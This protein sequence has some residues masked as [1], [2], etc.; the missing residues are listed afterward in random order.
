MQTYET[1]FIIRPNL[2]DEEVTKVVEKMKAVVVKSGGAILQA[3][4]WG[5]RKLAY[6]VEREKKGT[7]VIFR[8]S[9]DGKIIND[10]EHTY[11]MEDGIIKFLTVKPSKGDPG[12]LVMPTAEE[13]RPSRG[14]FSHDR[15]DRPRYDSG[16]RTD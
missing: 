4:N 10:L 9:G 5:K 11:R 12:T 1:I 7:Y 13:G 14:R 3:E 8:F 15:E 6:E 2:T 16:K